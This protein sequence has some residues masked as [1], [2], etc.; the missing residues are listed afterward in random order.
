M[1]RIVLS[2]LLWIATIASCVFLATFMRVGSLAFGWALNFLLMFWISIY[3]ETQT[4]ELNSPYFATRKWEKKGKVYEWVGINLFRQFLVLIGWEKLNKKSN[5]IEKS[6]T[7][8]AHNL[9]R[10]KKSE[11]G[12]LIIFL[13]VLGVSIA[14]IIHSGFRSA[15]W[16]IFFN[17][18]FNLYPVLLQRYNRPRIERALKLIERNREKRTTRSSQELTKGLSQL[19][20][21]SRQGKFQV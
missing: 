12:H 21:W 8:L 16:L 1:K 6:A 9:L 18:V 13:L 11:L 20:R 15:I 17:I 14:V 3:V 5:P 2:L 4:Q 19:T 7:A 10:T